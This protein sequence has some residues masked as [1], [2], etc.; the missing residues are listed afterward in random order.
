MGRELFESVPESRKTFEAADAALESSISTLCFDGS[1]EQ[2]AMTEN[3]QPAILTVSIAAH[4]ALRA[5]G[6]E[7]EGAA[8][9]SLGEYSAHVAAETISFAEA[10]QA[11]RARGRFMQAAVPVGEGAMAAIIGL[12][13]D[14]IM[15]I[16][17]EITSTDAEAVVQAANINAPG[18]IVLAGSAGAVERAIAAC[19]AAGAKRAIPL[20]VSAPFHCA[21]M[22]P[23]AEQL[24]PVLNAIEFSNPTMPVYTN[25]DAAAVNDGAAARDALLRQVAG[26]VR[27]TDLIER[28]LEDGFDT[29]VEIGPGKVLSGLMRRI[30][31]GT[32]CYAVSNVESLDQVV[33]N[34]GG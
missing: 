16:C 15:K 29:F 24:Q 14:A 27:W 23:A 9:H 33:Q 5:R 21:L 7:A 34:L 4:A 8:G 6:I 20:D 2:L 26:T 19:S 17:D 1:P 11:V 22:Q 13:L 18:Q 30:R 12:E 28:M 25:V 3:T 10:V 31:K 32:P